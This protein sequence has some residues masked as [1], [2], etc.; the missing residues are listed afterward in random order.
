MAKPAAKLKTESYA[1][2]MRY[3]RGLDHWTHTG[4]GQKAIADAWKAKTVR[5][6]LY[7]TID[8]KAAVV[9]DTTPRLRAEPLDGTSTME[10]RE[11]ASNAVRHELE[12]CRWDDIRE[13]AYLTAS[14]TS[15]GFGIA[16]VTTERDALTG[17]HRLALEAADVTRFY[18]DPSASRMA[19]CQ[20]VI[21][22]PDLDASKIRELCNAYGVPEKFQRIKFGGPEAAGTMPSSPTRTRDAEELVTGPGTQVALTPDGKIRARKAAVAF[23]WIDDKESLIR[24]TLS[25]TDA[26]DVPSDAEMTCQSCGAV[27]DF[28]DSDGC[29][30]CG[31]P[32]ATYEME[33]RMYPY[34]RLIVFCQDVLLY[35]G[36]N[37]LEINDPWI[38]PFAVYVK[39]R[40]P[41]EFG[42]FSDQDLLK[43]NQMQADKNAAQ[44]FDAMRL[45]ANGW[46]QVPMG[47]PEWQHVT[48]EPGQKVRVR[49][50]NAAVAR[51][52]GPV[53]YN[54]QLH[55]AAESM[56]YSDFQRISGQPD[57]AVTSGPS[58]PDSATEVKSRDATR[59]KRIGR[60]LKAF[61]RFSSDLATLSWQ[62]MVQYYV[63]PRPFMFS[64]NGSQFEAVVLD[65]STLPRNLH[66]RVE[67][68]IDALEK[69]KLAGQNLIMA[70]QAG[71]VPMMPD[72][73]LRAL[74]TPEPVINEVMN[75]PEM[76]IHMMMMQQQAATMMAGGAPPQGQPPNNQPS[77]GESE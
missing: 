73:L 14:V 76:Q 58:A 22:E 21:Y 39:G 5:N 19:K 15:A 62:V 30:V 43:S 54:G 63:G 72:L 59:N 1:K 75:R 2:D 51:V 49:P 31:M 6:Y 20:Y 24:E 66:I 67:A 61:N 44:L 53:G 45:T 7:A 48:N 42:G 36:P 70:M 17:E 71:V 60:E 55:V 26:K 27:Y 8:L 37:P 74:G 28:E 33:S 47:E 4:G 46:L 52:V 56:V 13:D 69:D 64:P 9:L 65:V 11:L 57:Q 25:T 23:I 3:W 16:Q 32:E 10:M 50:E 35:D 18:P 38:F 34:G 12:R 77:G 41:G 68:D 40:V 29:P